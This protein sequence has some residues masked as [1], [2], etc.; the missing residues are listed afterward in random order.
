MKIT[1]ECAEQNDLVEAAEILIN[2]FNNERIF[3]FYA[4]MGAGKTTFIRSIGA[5]LGC[6]D[7]ISSPTYPIVNEYLLRNG[8]PIY[9]FDFFRIEELEE[10]IALGFDEYLSSGNY[11]LIE[12]PEKVAPLLPRH[13]VKVEIKLQQ[14]D[15]LISMAIAEN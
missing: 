1:F 3:C 11:C 8:K 4:E 10:A 9:H 14:E 5:E 13:F 12:W 6:K 2:F 15:R 7:T